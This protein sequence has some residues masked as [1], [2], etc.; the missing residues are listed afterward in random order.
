MVATAVDK[1]FICGCAVCTTPPVICRVPVAARR[2]CAERGLPY[3]DGLHGATHAL[4][5]V[6]PLHLACNPEDLRAECDNPYSTRYRP[7]R[8]LIFDAHPGGIGLVKQARFMAACAM[9]LRL[10]V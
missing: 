4:L 2:I 7:E 1:P 9:L 3:R 8:I 10:T 5:N 6:L